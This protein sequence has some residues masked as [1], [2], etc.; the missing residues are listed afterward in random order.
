[1]NILDAFN[2]FYREDTIS[3]FLIN[4]FQDTNDF[5]VRF[6][7]EADI[8]VDEQTVF[9]VDTRVG[10]GENIGTPDIVIRALSNNE[11]KFIIVENK[12]GAAEGHE[13][14][15][16]YESIEAK[17]QIAQ[18]Y[19]VS[20]ENIEFHYIFLALDTTARPQNSQF[21]FLNYDIFLRGEWPLQ[22][23]TLKYIFEDFKNK[24]QHFYEPINNPY[25][26][27]ESDLDLDGMQLKICWQKVLFDAF[28]SNE[29]LV[30][31]WGEAGGAGRNNFIFLITKQNWTSER[32][33][34]EAG[35]RQTFNVHVDTY[36]NMLDRSKGVKEIGVRFESFPYEPHSK[37]K[38]S[39]DYD[40]F[41]E[42]K[43]IF[44]E[45]LFK[46]A[47][48]RGVIS[49]KRNTKLLVM[50]V[51]IEGATIQEKVHHIKR[52]FEAIEHCIDS[53]ISEMKADHLI[54]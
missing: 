41:L 27:L 7:S 17:F 40:T 44:G 15:I 52:Q 2:V 21:I 36:I 47:Q 13:Q 11:L 24:L 35:L 3:D 29:H 25:E 42:N 39:P 50:T 48:K 6:L 45:K 30:L 20:I 12:M 5:L 43:N 46:C 14:T 53:V 26:S 54:D 16:R 4:C 1:M 18:K 49:K 32:S 34:R 22:Q 37:I 8:L 31:D 33:F 10:L 23:K 9:Q 19:N 28:S 38:N 51:Q